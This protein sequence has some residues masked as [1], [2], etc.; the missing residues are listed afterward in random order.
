[1]LGSAAP[2]Q[3]RYLPDLSVIDQ[4]RRLCPS[5]QMV[6]SPKEMLPWHQLRVDTTSTCSSRSI[7]TLPV[8][9]LRHCQLQDIRHHPGL[10]PPMSTPDAQLWPRYLEL[11]CQEF[12]KCG[13]LP[14]LIYTNLFYTT[15]HHL[16][17]HQF[18]SM[19]A[20]YLPPLS[21]APHPGILPLSALTVW[22]LSSTSPS[23]SRQHYSY[24]GVYPRYTP[25]LVQ[26][27]PPSHRQSP[28][29]PG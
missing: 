28:V 12:C 6:F 4:W 1:M 3:T 18:P 21:Q 22:S 29:S 16:V 9:Y 25:P 8:L 20:R 24:A 26:Q 11:N 14:P 5:L 27:V 17:H 15:F 19:Y 10:Q 2:N 13:L 7:Y 23:P